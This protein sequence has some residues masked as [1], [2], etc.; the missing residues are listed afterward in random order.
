MAAA[1]SWHQW[2][3]KEI[4]IGERKAKNQRHQKKK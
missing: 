4:K 2:Q 3:C 1:A